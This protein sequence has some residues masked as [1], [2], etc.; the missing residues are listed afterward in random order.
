MADPTKYTISYSFSGWQA[1]NPAK[2]LPAQHVDDQFAGIQTSI[3]QLVDAVKDVRRSDGKL[4][5]ASVTIDSLADEV[6]V[7]WTGGAIAAWAPVVG[8]AAGI[9]ATPVAPAT[10]VFYNGETYLCAAAHTTT[11]LFETTKWTKLAAKGTSGTGDMVTTNN[12]S[13]VA[14]ID[15]ARANLN[16]ASPADVATA[17]SDYLSK[18]GNLAGLANKAAARANLALATVAASGAYGDLAGKPALGSA[19]SRNVGTG[20]GQLVELLAGGKLPAVDGSLLL[21]LSAVAPG[22]IGYT[23]E[24]NPP[25]GWLERNGAAISR[26]AYAALFA[27]IGTIF[28]AGDGS[29]TF[30][31]PDARGTFD[32]G[33][34]HGRGFDPGRVF[35]SYQADAVGPHTH[36]VPN[37]SGSSSGTAL[38]TS[39]Y[40]QANNMSTGSGGG[41]ETRPKNGAYLPI[42]KY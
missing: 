24:P 33:W 29:T 5:N 20:A 7:P 16:A 38:R 35:G 3:G 12:L 40:Y 14:N 2:P 1:S 8:Y 13:D 15:Q 19:A 25:A 26:T 31:L 32:R 28:G 6:K 30:N 11:A 27:R 41:S 10:V 42:I 21:G 9:A 23:A 4:K 39:A 22:M 36:T 37:D 34:D 17:L 18:S